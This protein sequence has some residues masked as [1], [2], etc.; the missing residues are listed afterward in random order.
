MNSANRPVEMPVQ[1][2]KGNGVTLTR[3]ESPSE[4]ENWSETINASGL[5]SV[6]ALSIIE[7]FFGIKPKV[8]S[9]RIVGESTIPN[10]YEFCIPGTTKGA[11]LTFRI[12]QYGVGDES[13]TEIDIYTKTGL[14]CHHQKIVWVGIGHGQLLV[15][16]EHGVL[17][18]A[19]RQRTMQ[20]RGLLWRF[21]EVLGF[22]IEMSSMRDRLN[23]F[24]CYVPAH[25]R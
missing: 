5:L 1:E 3:I 25:L 15:A 9:W 13:H 18:R 7:E 20:R 8:T 16:T 22:H 17:Y 11:E 12:W 14:S 10:T 2:T 19:T 6:K 21:S 23:Q 24:T 4:M